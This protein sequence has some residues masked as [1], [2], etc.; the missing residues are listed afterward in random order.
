MNEK[1]NKEIKILEKNQ[2]DILEVQYT[3]N[4]IKCLVKSLIEETMLKTD[5]KARRQNGQ[6]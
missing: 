1:F 2:T 5:L 3:L 4:Q 6:P